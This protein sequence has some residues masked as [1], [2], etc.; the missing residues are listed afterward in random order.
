M[1]KWIKIIKRISEHPYED[2]WNEG[3]SI[4]YECP[5]CGC[6]FFEKYEECPNCGI[7]MDTSDVR[8]VYSESDD[9]DYYTDE[10]SSDYDEEEW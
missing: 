5:K 8:A 1:E 2:D 6:S 9:D 10:D 7:E 4:E 3:E